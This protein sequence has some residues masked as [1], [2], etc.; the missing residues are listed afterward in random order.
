MEKNLNSSELVFCRQRPIHL[1]EMLSHVYKLQYKD[2]GVFMDVKKH[3]RVNTD[4]KSVWER[5]YDNFGD[6]LHSKPMGGKPLEV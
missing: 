6:F 1:G 3:L 5:E 2:L 4:T